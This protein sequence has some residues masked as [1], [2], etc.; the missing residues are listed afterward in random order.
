MRAISAESGRLVSVDASES[1]AGQH[2]HC[3]IQMS[4]RWRGRVV[5]AAMKALVSSVYGKSERSCRDPCQ[6]ICPD[7]TQSECD[8]LKILTIVLLLNGFVYVLVTKEFEY[9]RDPTGV[10]KQLGKVFKLEDVLRTLSVLPTPIQ[11]H[12]PQDSRE[13]LNHLSRS[14]RTED[15]ALEDISLDLVSFKPSTAGSFPSS[16]SNECPFSI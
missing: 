3:Q 8:S 10:E 16:R 14:R 4:L 7:V 9:Q 2:R 11:D 5:E 13:I 15:T 1:G 12:L 6:Q